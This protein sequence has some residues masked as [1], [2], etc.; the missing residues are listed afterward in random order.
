M[1][2]LTPIQAKFIIFNLKNGFYVQGGG[3]F[4]KIK[5]IQFDLVIRFLKA[6]FIFLCTFYPFA[7]SFFSPLFSFIF[8]SWSASFWKL[9]IFLCF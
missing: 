7:S 5:W 1:S 4:N 6:R 9:D 2:V 3:E 8:I